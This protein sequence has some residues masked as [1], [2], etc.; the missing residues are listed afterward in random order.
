MEVSKMPKL[1]LNFGKKKR[2]QEQAR[3]MKFRELM[4]K[5]GITSIRKDSG[6]IYEVDEVT[7][8][9]GETVIVFKGRKDHE[10]NQEIFA[11]CGLFQ[12]A[13]I[14]SVKTTA[15]AYGTEVLAEQQF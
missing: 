2:Q 13:R 8:E 12:R 14:E 15:I 5:Y 4:Q 1:T 9:P 3:Q 6:N 10:G 7:I 11:W